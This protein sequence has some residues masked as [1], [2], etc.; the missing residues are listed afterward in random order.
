V[1]SYVCSHCYEWQGLVEGLKASLPQDAVLT[2]V[3]A[4][5]NQYWP[6][7]QRAHLAAQKLG[8][9]DR[10]HKRM[11]TSVWE[12]HEFPFLDKTTGRPLATA[13]TMAD[14]ARVYA[15]GGGVTEAEFLK[16]T[17]SPQ[18]NAAVDRTEALVKGWRVSGTP[19][20]LVGG[21]YMVAP[22]SVS[23]EK[24]LHEL[25][26]FLV[27]LERSRLRKPAPPAK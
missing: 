15:K 23:S 27:S 11:F 8:V 9:A 17:T 2:Y 25:V 7:F 6:L 3:H 26:G 14:F 5:F 13:P 21:R 19:S 20:F 12:T 18:I 22:E 1:F 10:N 24:E 16:A 4:G